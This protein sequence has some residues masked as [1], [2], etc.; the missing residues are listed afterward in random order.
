MARYLN[1]SEAIRLDEELFNECHFGVEQLMELA[2]L[3][4]A[5][6]IVEVYPESKNVL[7]VSGPGN[8]GG[9]GLVCARHL[10]VFG[11]NPAIYYPKFAVKTLYK[12]L[13]LQCELFGIP[14]LMSCPEVEDLNS[15]YS[16]VVDAMFGFSFKPP[17]RDEFKDIMHN[18]IQMSTPCCS[19]DIPSGWHVEKGPHDGECLQPD[20]LI[21]LSAPKLCAKYFKGRYHYLGGRFIPP[22]LMEKYHLEYLKYPSTNSHLKLNSEI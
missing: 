8:N 5:T 12:N 10:K 21:S 4:C 17:V 16:L 1:Q 9:D 20:M 13:I 6:A 2:G 19:I 15:K 11:Y 22:Y 18:M 3:S 7:V 14:F